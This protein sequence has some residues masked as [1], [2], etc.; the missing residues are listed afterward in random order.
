MLMDSMKALFTELNPDARI[1]RII[2]IFDGHMNRA[3][4]AMQAAENELQMVEST[5]ETE[6]SMTLA[7]QFYL[8]YFDENSNLDIRG[9]RLISL[10]GKNNK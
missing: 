8:G 10:A 7:M 5:E 9:G 1:D 2:Q 4:E 3:K 6:L